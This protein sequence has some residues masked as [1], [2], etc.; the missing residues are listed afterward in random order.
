[1][2]IVTVNVAW[3]ILTVGCSHKPVRTKPVVENITESVYAAGT[4]KAEGQYQVFPTVSGIVE[5]IFV[6][7]ND[8]I[9]KGTLLMLIS[10]QS[11][12]INRE[13]ADL[14]AHYA[15]IGVNQEKLT[16]LRNNITLAESK[17]ANDSLLL[18]R[19]SNLWKHGIGTKM[20]LE[21]RQLACQN[22]KT[23][24]ESAKIRYD[25]LFRQLRFDAEQ[26]KNNLAISRS[27]EGDYAINS[28]M[29]GRIYK[30]YPEKGEIINPQMPI[31]IVGDANHFRMDLSVD[32]YDI[33]KI[34]AGQL[35]LLTMDSYKGELF[36]ARI[37][38]IDPF[39]N[40][41]T[42]TFIVEA[43]FM[44]QPPVLYPNLS[45]EANIIVSTKEHVITIPRNYLVDDSMVLQKNN[46]KKP[47][48]VGLKDYQKVEIVSGL[49]TDEDIYKPER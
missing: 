38:R 12:K 22:S 46:T 43:V 36:N 32:E 5:N 45:V 26:S 28:E 9:K 21:Q 1:M 29:D 8:I 11:V 42:K 31:A 35:V 34:R 3:L 2:R 33:V 4:I 30:I 47:V 14:A 27:K 49:S 15:D 25:E 23:M 16:D 17:F 41:R 44:N 39:M 48:R 13:N 18:I 24:L 7:E 37:S 19:Q 10:N 40:E 6:R 20:E